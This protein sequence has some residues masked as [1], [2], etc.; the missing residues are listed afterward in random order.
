ML[1]LIHGLER[2]YDRKTDDGNDTGLDEAARHLAPISNIN[3]L[4]G[5]RGWSSVVPRGAQLHSATDG[6]CWR[7]GIS[8][9]PAQLTRV[10]P[11]EW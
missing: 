1:L 11:V 2:R 10:A 7:K 9:P 3:N 4:V 8:L 6:H 5:Y